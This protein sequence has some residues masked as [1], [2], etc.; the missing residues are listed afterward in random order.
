MEP[1]I[2][3]IDIAKK[4][5]DVALLLGEK[6]KSGAFHNTPA[7]FATFAR[8]LTTRH[9]E[10]RIHACMEATGT[11]GEELALYLYRAGHVVSVVN[12]AKIKGFAQ[13]E[14][15]RTKTDKSDAALIARFCRAMRP[16]AWQPPAPEVKKLQALVRRLEELNGMLTQERN[17]LA[18][19]DEVVRPSI[20]E[21]ILVL[22]ERINHLRGLISD[23]IDQ[24]PKLRANRD[25]LQSIPGIGPTTSAIIL[26]EFGDVERFGDARHMA[27]F[28]GLTP[29]HRQSGS[30]V[31]G[32][33]R[34]SKT[35]SSRIRKALYMPAL[36]AMKHN[37]VVAALR[38]RLKGYGK[39]NMVIVGAAMRKLVHIIFGVLKSA[40]PFDA[41]IAMSQS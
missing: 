20:E 5:F 40:R 12:P 30:S 17:R 28:C 25:L 10:E 37:P 36:V 41:T 8:W 6:T 39:C 3:G 13:S 32:K 26:A 9:G 23:H 2:V 31:R 35:G 1:T 11:Y 29:R 38:E 14:L 24:N 7:G 22:Q 19:A 18:T 21:V 33:S 27:S 15:S 4:K 16:E 34:L